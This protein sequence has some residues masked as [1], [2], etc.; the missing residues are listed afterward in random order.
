MPTG[1]HR[2]YWA[3]TLFDMADR[4]FNAHCAERLRRAGFDVFLPQEA[5]VNLEL[6]TSEASAKRIFET[7]T[8]AI[9]E[10]DLVTACID[11]ETIDS[12]VACGVGIA[13]SFGIPVLALHTDIRQ[14]RGGSGHICKNPYVIGAIE[15]L[16]EVAPS[17]DRLL[18]L[19]PR[20]VH[21]SGPTMAKDNG[22]NVASGVAGHFDEVAHMYEGYVR[23]LHT[24]YQPKW[25]VEPFV[26]HWVRLMDG[27]IHVLEIGCGTG[28]LGP[29]LCRQ[30]AE[31]SYVGYDISEQMIAVA[32]AVS[33]GERRRYTS[34]WEEVVQGTKDVPFDIV[35]A[36]FTLHDRR[37]KGN[38]IGTVLPCVRQSGLIQI[39]DISIL[40]LPEL[41]RFLQRVVLT[42]AVAYDPRLTPQWLTSISEKWSLTLRDCR[43]A[44]PRVSFPSIE[45]LDEYLLTF[46]IY[47]GMDLPL[48]LK[49]TEASA[50]R[51]RIRNALLKQR[52]PFVD[53]RAFILCVL[54][55]KRESPPGS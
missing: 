5:D 51:D 3:N 44:V 26:D 48:G 14:H 24:W 36:M 6:H 12:G 52:F 49:P 25:R 19:L 23:R 43:L 33:G 39:A 42:P 41:T 1:K 11:Q 4:R 15:A 50:N 35:L 45:D 31:L 54:E 13:F 30:Y 18:E 32:R 53:Q 21:G 10:S 47:K 27:R 34:D 7:D 37:D 22:P 17:L 29:H 16:G 38:V 28:G 2:I 55:K 20:Y 9:L 46:G 8:R 40:D